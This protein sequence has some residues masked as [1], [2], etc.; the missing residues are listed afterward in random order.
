MSGMS[1][2]ILL[3]VTVI[4]WLGFL[5]ASLVSRAKTPRAGLRRSERNLMFSTAILVAGWI[6][7]FGFPPRSAAA[8]H[9]TEA[10]AMA[11]GKTSHGSC[12]SIEVGMKVVAVKERLGTADETRTDEATRGPGAEIL[13]YRDSRCAIH[14]L[15]GTVEFID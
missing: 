1:L 4:Q 2:K 15:D 10:S 9:V 3:A 12:A 14:L 5:V 6:V 11:G 13:I 7:A 8:G